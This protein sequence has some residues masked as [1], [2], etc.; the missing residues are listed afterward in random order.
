M[1]PDGRYVPTWNGKPVEFTRV[2]DGLLQVQL[3]C[4]PG[5]LQ[6]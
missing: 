5:E 4:E 2:N 1:N 6:V 3:P